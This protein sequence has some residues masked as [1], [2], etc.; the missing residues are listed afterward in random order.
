MT[1]DWLPDWFNQL[2]VMAWPLVACS[3]IALTLSLERI[4]FYCTGYFKQESKYHLLANRLAE[5]KQLPKSVRDEIMT[6]MLG[7]MQR[8]YYSSIKGLRIIG[9]MSPMLGL[10][11][12]IF[13][14]IAAFQ[15][16]ADHT[17]PVSPSMIA[18]GLWEA[19]L[20]TAVG[21]SIALTSLFMAHL[22][23]YISERQLG[24]LCARL[25]QLSLSFEIEGLQ[26]TLPPTS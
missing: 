16:I 5:H 6:V 26:D 19:M 18:D 1:F 17:G 10:L 3:V 14:I 9:T 24:N 20:T 8:S 21:L 4:V 15:V 2:G 11:G 12:T 13:G 25:N 7:Q 22:Y 23:K